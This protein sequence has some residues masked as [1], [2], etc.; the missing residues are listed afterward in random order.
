VNDG[1]SSW[2]SWRLANSTGEGMHSIHAALSAALHTNTQIITAAHQTDQSGNYVR[3]AGERDIITTAGF[4]RCFVEFESF[5]EAAFAH[6]AMGGA[7]TAGWTPTRY[8]DPPNVDHAHSMFVGFQK[9]MDWSTPDRV[10]KLAGWYFE[11]GEPFTTPLASAHQDILDMKTVRNGC[12]HV[13]RTTGPAMDALFQR[14]TGKA[15]ASVTAYQILTAISST[16]SF[17]FLQKSEQVL[18][19]VCA[20]VA[21]K[22]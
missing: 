11:Q 4:V 16:A 18:L 17:S 1:P 12:S 9:F 15:Q 6:Y 10:W 22:T 7:S 3:T 2:F 8:V 19:S 20:Q 13:S 21:N 5:L 14:W